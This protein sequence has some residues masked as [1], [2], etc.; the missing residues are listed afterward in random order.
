I[1][2]KIE[3]EIEQKI[4]TCDNIFKHTSFEKSQPKNL[5]LLKNENCSEKLEYNKELFKELFPKCSAHLDSKNIAILIT[6]TRLIGMKVPGLNSIYSDLNLDFS[7]CDTNNKLLF[8]F[9]KHHNI[10][11]YIINIISPCKGKIKAFI[12]PQLIKNPTYLSLKAKYPILQKTNFFKKQKALIVGA[13]SGIGNICAKLLALGGAD[14]LATYNSNY[15]NEIIPNCTFIPLNI[16]NI[17]KKSINTI[18]EFNPTHVYY[19]ATPKISSQNT[20]LNKKILNDFIQYYIFALDKILSHIKP[21]LIFTSSSSSFVDD[22]PLDMKEYSI[23]KAAMEVYM[24]YI[25]KIKNTQIIMPRFPRIKTN[26]TL[27]LIPQNLKEPD[28]L[29]YPILIQIGEKQ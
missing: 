16:L 15:P 21:I 10:E 22:L 2:S 29:I 8:N 26:Q 4:K 19:F 14:I 11:C 12:R 7:V 28:E 24:K 1:F 20:N 23:A 6:S 13:S 9:E 25:E 17:D 5:Q 18:K 27:S 3:F